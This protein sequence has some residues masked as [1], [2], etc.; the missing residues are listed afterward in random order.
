MAWRVELKE[1][2]TIINLAGAET[3]FSRATSLSTDKLRDI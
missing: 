3:V 2:V 1:A